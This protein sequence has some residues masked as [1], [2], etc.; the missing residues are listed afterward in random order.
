M[1]VALPCP[2]FFYEL[3]PHNKKRETIFLAMIW[4]SLSLLSN[5]N[6]FVKLPLSVIMSVS[7]VYF[8]ED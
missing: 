8:K 6:I 2:V 4:I 1:L 3:D 7:N 5:N